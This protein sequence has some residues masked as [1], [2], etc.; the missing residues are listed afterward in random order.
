[1]SAPA[2]FGLPSKPSLSGSLPRYSEGVSDQWPADADLNQPIDLPHDG[3]V[4]LSLLLDEELEFAC[5]LVAHVPDVGRPLIVSARYRQRPRRCERTL[6]AATSFALTHLTPN[7]HWLFAAVRP[8]PEALS[9]NRAKTVTNTETLST[10]STPTP[11][12]SP[13]QV[14]DALVDE[15]EREYPWVARPDDRFT[16]ALVLDVGEVLAR[17]GY[18]APT[19]ATLVDLAVGLY[20]ALHQSPPP[21]GE[22]A[23]LKAATWR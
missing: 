9:A 13:N 6:S 17:H 7:R 10:D 3:R 8:C 15:L 14:D 23:S 18:P 20:R 21:L 19:G 16:L 5:Y 12:R 11:V 22:T 4:R 1:M 2:L